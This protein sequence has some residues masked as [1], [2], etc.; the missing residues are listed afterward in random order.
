MTD[1]IYTALAG[2]R[3]MDQNL[4]VLG[5]NLANM[6]TPGYKAQR[7]VFEQVLV[8]RLGGP[9][10][11]PLH[12]RP[13]DRRDVKMAGTI[14]DN[15]QGG[16]VETGNDMDIALSGEGFLAV[17]TQEGVRYTRRGTMSINPD[18]VLTVAGLPLRGVGGQPLEVPEDT[19]LSIDNAGVVFAGTEE[20]G[21]LELVKFEKP[22]DLVPV[23]GG[24]FQANGQAL[25]DEET[26]VVQGFIENSNVN[27]VWGMTELIRTNRIFQAAEKAIAA[28][29]SIDET[30]A[31]QVGRI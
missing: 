3:V 6:S 10:A 22:A 1:G 21:Q 30:L 23:G 19:N 12:G 9:G 4:E 16:L 7:P 31:S 11:A 15:S 28:F 29:K 27:P 25:P 5:N 13:D 14:M 2:A 20:I 18:Q 24:L 17:Q 26:E 8:R